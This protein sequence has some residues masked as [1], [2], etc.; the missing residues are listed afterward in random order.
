ML[1]F[2]RP[3]PTPQTTDPE[4]LLTEEETLPQPQA[5]AEGE[6]VTLEDGRV[7]PRAFVQ[8][9]RGYAADELKLILEEQQVLYTPE[10]FAYIREVFHERL[11]DI[12]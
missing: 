9:I 8:E 5:T 7:F 11:G 1:W 3:A 10:E 4:D 2:K 12:T 6:M